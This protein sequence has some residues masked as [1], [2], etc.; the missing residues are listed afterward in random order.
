MGGKAET[1]EEKIPESLV[2]NFLITLIN[3][4]YQKKLNV[5]LH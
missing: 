5:I 4:Y 3:K 2:S 1:A